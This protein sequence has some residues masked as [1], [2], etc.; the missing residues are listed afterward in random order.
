MAM[1]QYNL[2]KEY[3]QFVNRLYYITW[4]ETVYTK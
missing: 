3:Y 1:K 2:Y 4:L